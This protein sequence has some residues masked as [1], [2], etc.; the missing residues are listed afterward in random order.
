[1]Q[2][3]GGFI[4]LNIHQNEIFSALSSNYLT[5]AS[6]DSSVT[7]INEIAYGS[8]ENHFSCLRDINYTH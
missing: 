6:H 7:Y 8:R 2:H 4:H 1:M 3:I 5:S